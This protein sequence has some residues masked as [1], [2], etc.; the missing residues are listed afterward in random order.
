MI[1]IVN[2]L[3]GFQNQQDEIRKFIVLTFK[4]LGETVLYQEQADIQEVMDS[5]S[6]KFTGP[7]TADCHCC[8]EISAGGGQRSRSFYEGDHFT[9]K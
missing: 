6:A 7:R 2:Y 5:Y 4:V 1:E 8:D 9:E 3:R